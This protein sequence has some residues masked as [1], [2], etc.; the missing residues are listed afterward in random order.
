[1]QEILQTVSELPFTDEHM[2]RIA[3]PRGVAWTALEKYVAT[4][5]RRTE[6]GLLTRLL[7]AEPRTGF[8]I[9]ERVP[10]ERLTLA[11]RHRFARY[12]LVFD[13]A[14]VVDGS[15]ELRAIT[16]AEFPGLRG[17]A[18]RALVIGTRAHVVA[19]THILRSIRRRALKTVACVAL[20]VSAFL[21]SGARW[22]SAEV[23]T[24]IAAELADP[25][26]RPLWV[27][28]EAALGT[29]GSLRSELFSPELVAAMEPPQRAEPEGDVIVTECSAVVLYDCDQSGPSRGREPA[30]LYANSRL[31]L[32]GKVTH[33]RQGFFRETV[34]QLLEVAVDETIKAPAGAQ[35][36]RSLLLFLQEALVSPRLR[37]FCIDGASRRPPA[38]GARVLLLLDEDPAAGP[39]G[40]AVPLDN[41]LFLERSK[42]RLSA[43]RDFPAE[44]LSFDA[45]L[46]GLREAR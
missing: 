13:L 11:G 29:D 9:V 45:L 32:A 31:I 28:V 10:P 4:F 36:H 39:G 34:G 25:A 7:R 12:R 14:E 43:P 8:E 6:G 18:Y 46:R 41:D 15:T 35:S 42:G 33:S 44:G 22:A 1:M 38:I 27:S 2:V 5:L 40:V 37:R 23:P 24:W 3:A 21:G 16:H 26:G 19:T 20:A 17:S 30:E